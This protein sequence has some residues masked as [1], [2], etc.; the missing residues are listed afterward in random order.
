M[1]SRNFSVRPCHHRLQVWNAK[2]LRNNVTITAALQSFLVDVLITHWRKDHQQVPQALC[3]RSF[4]GWAT[5]QRS[6]ALSP[7]INDWAIGRTIAI[8]G[9]RYMAC[10]GT[11]QHISRRLA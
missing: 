5:L 8:A 1:R 11:S 6:P 9:L 10:K 7:L 4:A 2:L 3:K